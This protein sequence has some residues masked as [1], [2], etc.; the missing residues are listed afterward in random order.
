MSQDAFEQMLDVQF[1]R[2][3]REDLSVTFRDPLPERA[4]RELSHLA[5]SIGRKGS[6]RSARSVQAGSLSRDVALLGYAGGRGAPSGGGPP[7]AG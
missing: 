4:V 5:G 2:A 6:A 1:Q 7:R 3:W